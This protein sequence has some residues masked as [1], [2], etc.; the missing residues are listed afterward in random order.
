MADVIIF[1]NNFLK[2][3]VKLL[4]AITIKLFSK[5]YTK[6]ISILMTFK[7]SADVISPKNLSQFD[8]WLQCMNRPKLGANPIPCFFLVSSTYLHRQFQLKK[9]ALFKF[10]YVSVII[11]AH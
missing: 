8:Q 1:G 11:S 9:T 2:L 5:S 3:I 6:N 4:S 7:V 10:F